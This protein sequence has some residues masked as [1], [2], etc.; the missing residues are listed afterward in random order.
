VRRRERASWEEAKGAEGIL[1]GARTGGEGEGGREER[2][3]EEE[4]E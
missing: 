4:E 2:G 3:E 1:S